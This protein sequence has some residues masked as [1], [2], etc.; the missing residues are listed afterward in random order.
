MAGG[1]TAAPANV[2]AIEPTRYF[3]WP[4]S[5]A[6]SFLG[7]NPDLHAA[8]QTTLALDFTKWL[9]GSWARHQA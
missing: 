2:V 1:S 6:K 5:R 9:H 7:N 3:V 4:K 8:L